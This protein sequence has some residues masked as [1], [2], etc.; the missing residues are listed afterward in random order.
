MLFG[1]SAAQD[2]LLRK[3]LLADL[4]RNPPT[5]ATAEKDGSQPA[6][7]AVHTIDDSIVTSLTARLSKVE[8]ELRAAKADQAVKAHQISELKKENELLRVQAAGDELMQEVQKLRQDNEY[9]RSKTTEMESFLED[10]GLIWIGEAPGQTPA[11]PSSGAQPL[12]ASDFVVDYSA[13]L[14]KLAELNHMADA[15][16]PEF[17]AVGD[18]LRKLK[19]VTP[20]RLAFY[21]NGFMCDGQFRSY[22]VTLNRAYVN[23]ILDGYFPNE[24]KDTFPDGVPFEVDMSVRGNRPYLVTFQGSG[25]ALGGDSQPSRL[26]P[27]NFRVADRGSFREFLTHLPETAIADNGQVVQV[28]AGIADFVKEISGDAAPAPVASDGTAIRVN[29]AQSRLLRD[30]PKTQ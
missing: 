18:N 13:I 12:A 8:A 3:K 7:A 20:V 1:K 21:A 10:Y 5:A 14:Q 29:V 2:E 17:S 26:I 9:L 30:E 11:A 23:D 28:R 4:M 27:S 25:R 15:G 6:A 16:R 24:Y 22:D 19:H